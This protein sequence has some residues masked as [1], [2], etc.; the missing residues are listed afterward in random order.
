MDSWHV[1]TLPIHERMSLTANIPTDRSE[2]A[3]L[4]EVHAIN[5]LLW[6]RLVAKAKISTVCRGGREI[7]YVPIQSLVS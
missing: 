5:S 4:E 7:R 6:N 3:V 1:Y 2:P